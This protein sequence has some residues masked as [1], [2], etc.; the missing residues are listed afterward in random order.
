MKNFST[1]FNEFYVWEKIRE[2]LTNFMIGMN[3][4]NNYEFSTL[5]YELYRRTR[6]LIDAVHGS[7]GIGQTAVVPYMK[8]SFNKLILRKF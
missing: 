3:V 4:W 1:Y 6:L 8:N 5:S 2:L 7:G